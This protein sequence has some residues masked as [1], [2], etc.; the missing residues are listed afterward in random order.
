[1]NE[2]QIEWLLRNLEKAC[3]EIKEKRKR[4]KKKKVALS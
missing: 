1:V 4:K 3:V 2:Y